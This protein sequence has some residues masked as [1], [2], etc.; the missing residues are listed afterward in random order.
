M[1]LQR[2]SCQEQHRELQAQPQA[3]AS[4]TAVPS[5]LS[6]DIGTSSLITRPLLI[7]VEN[8]FAIFINVPNFISHAKGLSMA[9]Y[10]HV[11]A[12]IDVPG[13]FS[14]IRNGCIFCWTLFIDPDNI[15]TPFLPS[16]MQPYWDKVYGYLNN[17]ADMA[18][19]S[20]RL[21][22]VWKFMITP[23]G[24][25]SAALHARINGNPHLSPSMKVAFIELAKIA[26]LLIGSYLVNQMLFWC[27]NALVAFVLF[28]YLNCKDMTFFTNMN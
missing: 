23:I 5:S 15:S 28:V 17:H 16:S 11:N 7:T 10:G 8:L 3:S 24:M 6:T 25:D 14:S 22:G 21:F 1:H 19:L 2:S 20:S 18:L 4:S 26:E 27:F 13:T 9:L 12:F